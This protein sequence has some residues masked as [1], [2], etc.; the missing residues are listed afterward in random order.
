MSA[1]RLASL[2]AAVLAGSAGPALRAGPAPGPDAYPDFPAALR[3]ARP[4]DDIRQAAVYTVNEAIESESGV[5]AAAKVG[6]DV[7]IRAWF[8]W[9]QASDWS[10]LAPLAAKV[11]ALGTLFGGGV[12]CSALYD[13]ENGLTD[14]Q[15]RDMATRDPQSRLVDAWGQPGIR[16]GSLSSP[17]YLDYILSWCRRQI[18][19]GADYLFMDE[20][21]AA[22]RP[23]EGFDDYSLRE[24]RAHLLRAYVE[25]RKWSPADTRWTG[26]FGID[27]ADRAVCPDGSMASF[28]YRAYLKARGLADKPH[29]PANPLARAWQDFRRERDDRAWKHLT[30]A[31]RAYAAAKGRRVYISANGIAPY[32][33]LQVLGVWGLWRVRGGGIDLAESQVQDW[34]AVVRAGRAKAGR[35]VPVVFF[36]DW[37]FGGFPWQQVQPRDRN[38]WMRTRGAEIY[39]AGAFFAFPVRGPFGQDAIRDGTVREI[40]R[41][42]AFYQRHRGLYLEGQVAGLEPLRASEPMLSLALWTRA[43]PPA[44]LLHVINRQARDGAPEPRR[45]V[46]VR[47]PAAA[48]PKR[49]RIVSPDWEG[50]GD[51]QA[52]MEQGGLAVTLPELEAYAVAILEYDALPV[53]RLDLLA[54]IPRNVWSRPERNE[55]AVNARGEVAGADDLVGYVQGNLHPDLAGPPTFL[56]NMP[57]GGAMKVHVRAVATLGARL[58]FLV[59]GRQALAADL[60]DRDGK[61]DAEASEY[62]RTI[63]VPVPPGRHRIAVRNTGGDWAY[64]GWYSFAGRLEDW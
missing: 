48:A 30:D 28:D 60:P 58:E 15:V 13:G 17:A 64:V 44:I 41:Q 25:G 37:G 5:A 55:F 33:D 8:K 11:H 7:A 42:T 50:E 14:E 35:D 36:H 3:R 46:T 51:G 24:F 62:A 9:R 31:I 52:R 27:L 16:H 40:A 6:S 45:G 43:A 20:I 49:V 2:L 1:K 39:A 12:T 32:V 34:A 59:D 57:Q 56:V 53:V 22:L 10:P 21:N 18:D 47:V 26:E 23:P 61:N 63:E 29:G 54:V 38:L 19:A 4:V